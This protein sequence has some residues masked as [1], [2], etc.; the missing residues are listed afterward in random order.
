MRLL[1]EEVAA[2]VDLAVPERRRLR[3][4]GGDAEHGARALGV[5]ERDDRRVEPHEAAR[6]EEAVDRPGRR[7]P[8][9]QHGADR[10]GARP[11]VGD[12]AEILEAVSLLLERVVG[13]G[14]ADELDRTRLELE[15]LARAR[16]VD[17]LAAQTHG[18]AVREL[19]HDGL[20]LRQRRLGQRLEPRE[21]G[22]VVQHQEGTLLRVARAPHPA[23]DGHLAAGDAPAQQRRD[24]LALHAPSPRASRSPAARSRSAASGTSDDCRISYFTWASGSSK[25]RRCGR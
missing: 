17:E 16:R 3:V 1:A 13:L 7:V 19:A 11:Q 8:H 15:A 18:V 10:V 23:L 21:A 12:R 22:A 4:E 9:A 2:P 24:A 5:R 6:L 14:A 25:L 20:V